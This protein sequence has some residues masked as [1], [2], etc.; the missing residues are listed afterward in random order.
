MG[1]SAKAAMAL[2]PGVWLV[3]AAFLPTVSAWARSGD[4]QALRTLYDQMGGEHWA[5]DPELFGSD[6]YM[7]QNWGQQLL[8][9]GRP[10]PGPGVRGRSVPGEVDRR[11]PDCGLV[12]C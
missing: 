1:T 10:H 3:G 4:R 7:A 8:E 12:R 11:R 2:K 9:R 6:P 5:Q